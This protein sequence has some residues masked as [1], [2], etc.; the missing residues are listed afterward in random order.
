MSFKYVDEWKFPFDNLA[1][2]QC[3]YVAAY[4]LNQTSQR[5]GQA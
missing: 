2:S 4:L 3:F 5:Q 1:N